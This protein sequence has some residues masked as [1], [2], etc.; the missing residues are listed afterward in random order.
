MK[1]VKHEEM[2]NERGSRETNLCI[3]VHVCAQCA[4]SQCACAYV[5]MHS[6]YKTM[7]VYVGMLCIIKVI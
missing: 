7:F 2:R 4:C 5:C 6:L 3:Y 1:V